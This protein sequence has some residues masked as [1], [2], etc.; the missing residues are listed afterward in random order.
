V[1]NQQISTSSNP[2]RTY[3]ELVA[4]GQTKKQK[5]RVAA[6]SALG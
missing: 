3:F 5:M 2:H 6:C 4:I 1:K